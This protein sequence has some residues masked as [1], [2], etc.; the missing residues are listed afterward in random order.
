MVR[1]DGQPSKYEAIATWLESLPIDH[2]IR[3]KDIIEKFNIPD[4]T[5]RN[6][7]W[8]IVQNLGILEG[9]KD[10]D[11]QRYKGPGSGLYR[12]IESDRIR[13]SITSALQDA[14][15]E[16]SPTVAQMQRPTVASHSPQESPLQSATPTVASPQTH[17][18]KGTVKIEDYRIHNIEMALTKERMEALG[19]QRCNL[20]HMGVSPQSHQPE[21]TIT[22]MSNLTIPWHV[23]SMLQSYSSPTMHYNER[24]KEYIDT[25]E[26]EDGR[27]IEIGIYQNGSVT[28]QVKCSDHDLDAGGVV[29]LN[30]F[31]QGIFPLKCGYSWSDLADLFIVHRIEMNKDGNITTIDRKFDPTTCWTFKDVHGT[32]ARIYKRE[33]KGRE[34]IRTEAILEPQMPFSRFQGEMLALMQGGVTDYQVNQMFMMMMTE[35]KGLRQD[36]KEKNL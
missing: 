26:W 18:K 15:R 8:R 21:I 33:V 17:P 3:S 32:Y 9:V 4:G 19:L 28:I 16:A 35:I 31:L 20:N 30:G 6:Y 2:I 1:R 29:A 24:A 12:R 36:L 14:I 34:G 25:I 27:T 11:G 22:M 7:I 5:A 10:K 23:Y 13:A